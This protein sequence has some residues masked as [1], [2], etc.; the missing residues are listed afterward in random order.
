MRW[1]SDFSEMIS[2]DYPFPDTYMVHVTPVST[3]GNEAYVFY[4]HDGE[5]RQM[6]TSDI[7]ADPPS[8]TRVDQEMYP[9]GTGS[10][11]AFPDHKSAYPIEQG[12]AVLSSKG[13]TET[14]QP[15]TRLDFVPFHR[16]YDGGIAGVTQPRG[17]LKH[18]EG[19]EHVAPACPY[20]TSLPDG[21]RFNLFF[22]K[23]SP[24]GSPYDKNLE[25]MFTRVSPEV[26]DPQSYQSIYFVPWS[27]QAISAGEASYP[28]YGF[29][30]KTIRMLSDTDGD[31]TLQLDDGRGSWVDLD[32]VSLTAN[33]AQWYQTTHSQMFMRLKFS[34]AATVTARVTVEPGK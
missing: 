28:F 19:S 9:A 21:R 10:E 18:L 1:E 12:V 3:Y 20:L 4:R 30:R 16:D 13:P 27:D 14:T 23:E 11:Y 31:M 32:T 33:D 6:Y 8:W 2:Y 34:A 7:T 24:M 25:L 26:L 17:I 22:Q 15:S 5:H 29:G